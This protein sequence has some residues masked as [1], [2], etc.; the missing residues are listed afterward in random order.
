MN[1]TPNAG[2]H[3]VTVDE[4]YKFVHNKSDL[5]EAVERN[6]WYLPKRKSNACTEEFLKKVLMGKTWCPKYED[7]RIRPCPRPP[8]K[9]ILYEKF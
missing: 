4:F 2:A 3:K 7:I 8:S 5:Y 1:S 6:G 9:K